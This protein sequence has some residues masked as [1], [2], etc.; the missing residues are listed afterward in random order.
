MAYWLMTNHCGDV[1]LV[2]F[3]SQNN[4]SKVDLQEL[5]FQDYKNQRLKE[6]SMVK[7]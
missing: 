2:R 3:G 1:I 5:Q 7:V 4:G 6:P